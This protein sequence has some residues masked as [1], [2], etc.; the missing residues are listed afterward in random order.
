MKHETLIFMKVVSGLFQQGVITAQKRNCLLNEWRSGVKEM[1][2]KKLSCLVTEVMAV[3]KNR[4][5]KSELEEIR[6]ELHA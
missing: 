3:N 1:D 6:E 4:V 2:R 5:W